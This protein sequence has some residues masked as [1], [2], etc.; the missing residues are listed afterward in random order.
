MGSWTSNTKN[1]TFFLFS[2]HLP[3]FLDGSCVNYFLW[4]KTINTETI[5]KESSM[6]TN[7]SKFWQRRFTDSTP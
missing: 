2:S 3:S 7:F 1:I 5:H 4:M 6:K